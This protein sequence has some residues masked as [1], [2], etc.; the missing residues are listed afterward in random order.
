M[1]RETVRLREKE[2]LRAKQVEIDVGKR[3]EV[4]GEHVRLQKKTLEKKH[5][6]FCRFLTEY[7]GRKRGGMWG[8]GDQF[9]PILQY[10]R[11]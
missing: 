9:S 5:L 1:K 10:S 4:Q 11:K 8:A 2:R 3:I 7:E 6:Y